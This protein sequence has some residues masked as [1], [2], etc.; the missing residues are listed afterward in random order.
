MSVNTEPQ[1][2]T[3]PEGILPDAGGTSAEAFLLEARNAVVEIRGHADAAN[4]AALASG[5]SLRLVT[6]A[7]A[8]AAT[9]LADMTAVAT[10]VVAMKTQI[11]DD[12][13]VIATKSNHIEQ[14]KEHADKVRDELDRTLTAA[15]QH[16]VDAEGL[17]ARAQSAVDSAVELLT[18]IRTNKG[19][20]EA[21]AATITTTRDAAK[22][23]A[24]VLKGLADKS[25]TVE[26]TI[27]AYEDRLAN[28]E[29]QCADQ[30]KTIEGL[31]PGATSAGLAHAFDERRKTFLGPSRWWQG[32]FVVSVVLLVVLAITG[33]W[34]VYQAEKTLT[35]DDLLRLWIARLPV[36]GALVWLALH[37]SH[38]S[39]LA[40]RLEEDYGYKA[41]ISS[42][43][44]G[45]H[46]QMSEIGTATGPDGP[47]AKLCGDTLATIASPPGRI[48]DKHQLTVS[49]VDEL[50]DV[51]KSVAG[52]I[53]GAHG[54]AM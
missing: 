35:Y 38:E 12:Q 5:E 7:H 54:P 23:S 49:P 11:S 36:A 3:T 39:A 2:S 50:K 52:Q 20:V 21:D 31:L 19:L 28:L 15:S 45:F 4:A 34:H 42:S 24:A 47:L 27:K 10:Q 6:A 16:S 13:A 17:K 30:L 44:Q 8:E 29:S 41:A 46:K 1:P 48:Y 33:V 32:L 14:A 26:A 51:A 18:D 22:E 9:K 53:N 40:K 43:F 37:A 25:A